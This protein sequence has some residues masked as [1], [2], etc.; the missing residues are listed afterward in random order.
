MT[1]YLT[2]P[3]SFAPAFNEPLPST[4]SFS[5]PASH[6]HFLPDITDG[7]GTPEWTSS[8]SIDGFDVMP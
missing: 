7:D 6:W 2:L 3:K 5:V 1:I 4:L 8:F